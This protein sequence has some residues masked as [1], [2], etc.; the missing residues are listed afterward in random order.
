ME[1]RMNLPMF[2]AVV[3]NFGEAFCPSSMELRMNLSTVVANF[4]ESFC[5]SSMEDWMNI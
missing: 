3:P 4:A 1:A 2:G 5:H